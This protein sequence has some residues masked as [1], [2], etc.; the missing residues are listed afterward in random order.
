MEVIVFQLL[1]DLGMNIDDMGDR[2]K[3]RAK[4]DEIEEQFD[5]VLISERFQESVLL[6]ADTLCWDMADVVFQKQLERVKSEVC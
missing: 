2:E 5:L 3:V 6:M 4:L 1:W